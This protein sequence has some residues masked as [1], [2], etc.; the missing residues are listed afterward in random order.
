MAVRN[1]YSQNISVLFVKPCFK[2]S[3]S[4]FPLLEICHKNIHMWE[5]VNS[6]G[7]DSSNSMHSQEGPWS[8][9]SSWEPSF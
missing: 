2:M 3:D 9:A 1:R 5:R 8:L 4:V 7:L 6:A